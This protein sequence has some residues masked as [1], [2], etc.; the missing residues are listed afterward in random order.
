MERRAFDQARAQSD[1]RTAAA[2][3]ISRSFHDAF[4]ATDGTGTPEGDIRT[5]YFLAYDEG[6]CDYFPIEDGSMEEAMDAGR[7]LVSTSF[8]IPYPPGFPIL[9]PGQVISQGNPAL[10]ARARRQ[11][12]PRLPAGSRHE[13]LFSRRVE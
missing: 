7:E 11:G 9:V 12:D 1:R 13:G 10:H 3:P 6:K 4:R 8:I 5:A 2:C